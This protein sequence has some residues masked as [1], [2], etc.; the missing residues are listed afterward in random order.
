[1]SR[2]TSQQ[3]QAFLSLA[4]RYS[5]AVYEVIKQGDPQ[6]ISVSSQDEAIVLDDFA[7]KVCALVVR[8]HPDYAGRDEDINA[9]AE[10]VVKMVASVL[11]EYGFER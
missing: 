1:M 10:L 4:R 2:F 3:K 11:A 6:E 8:D 9:D 7:D 5:P